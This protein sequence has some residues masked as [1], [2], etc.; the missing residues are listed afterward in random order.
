M[1]GAGAASVVGGHRHNGLRQR[2][3]AAED[4]GARRVRARRD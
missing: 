3:P 2:E 4:E 1:I